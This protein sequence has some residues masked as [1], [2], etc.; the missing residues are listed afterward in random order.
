[1]PVAPDASLAESAK[2]LYPDL[3]N[4]YG[5]SIGEETRVGPFVEIQK[6]ASIGAR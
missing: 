2:V 6:N 5:C 3:V 4:I 1:M